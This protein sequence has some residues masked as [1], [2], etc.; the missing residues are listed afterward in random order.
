MSFH[1]G[2]RRLSM[3]SFTVHIRPY[4]LIFVHIRSYSW[5]HLHSYSS[6]SSIFV[7]LR[8]H[9]RQFTS[10][11]VHLRPLTSIDVDHL[12]PWAWEAWLF[13]KYKNCFFRKYKDPIISNPYE[14]N[15][16]QRKIENGGYLEKSRFDRWKQGKSTFSPKTWNHPMVIAVIL[17]GA[18]CSKHT[19]KVYVFQKMLSVN[20]RVFC[21]CKSNLPDRQ[22]SIGMFPDT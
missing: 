11:Y 5:L 18:V 13:P 21:E 1:G 7:H 9:L 10:I 6:Y 8:Y 14:M 4:S 2:L 12:R 17:G 15:L 20:V 19:L 3:A 16:L 22:P